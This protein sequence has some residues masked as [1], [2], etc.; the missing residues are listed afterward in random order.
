M[1]ENNLGLLLTYLSSRSS[2]SYLLTNFTYFSLP[3]HFAIIH[4]YLLHSLAFDYNEIYE[5]YLQVYNYLQNRIMKYK[6][7]IL[8]LT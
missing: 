1:E 5:R 3:S 6:A 2:F 7:L 8:D 4:I